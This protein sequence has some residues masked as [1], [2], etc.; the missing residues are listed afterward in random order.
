MIKIKVSS[1]WIH[2]GSGEGQWLFGPV[3]SQ[4]EGFRW[5]DPS[6]PWHPSGPSPARAGP[7]C[8]TL[9][10]SYLRVS[11][12]ISRCSSSGSSQWPPGSPPSHFPVPSAVWPSAPTPLCPIGYPHP[13]QVPG[14]SG[15]PSSGTPSLCLLTVRATEAS[16]SEPSPA[17]CGAWEGCR[18]AGGWEQADRPKAQSHCHPR[19]NASCSKR[20]KNF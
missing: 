3:C 12:L 7:S 18:G 9:P 5:L 19:Q 11:G 16:V 4:W 20:L 6:L 2:S 13:Y 15:S 8:P 1:L 14:F 17:H 10:G